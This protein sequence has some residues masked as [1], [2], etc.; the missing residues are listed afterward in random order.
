MAE[1]GPYP[2]GYGPLV[3]LNGHGGVLRGVSRCRH[4]RAALFAVHEYTFKANFIPLV[5]MRTLPLR[6]GRTL[7]V[8]FR[9][10][11]RIGCRS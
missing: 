7:N 3:I 4:P 8:V 2:L 11:P 5:G 6:I 9:V 1:R 10:N